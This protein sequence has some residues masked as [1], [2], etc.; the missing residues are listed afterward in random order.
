MI[1]LL[2][3]ENGH[4]WRDVHPLAYGFDATVRGVSIELSITTKRRVLVP[5]RCPYCNALAFM[6]YDTPPK[7][8]RVFTRRRAKRPSG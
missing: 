3:C 5:I 2:H 7:R 8:Q 1:F 6:R 4:E